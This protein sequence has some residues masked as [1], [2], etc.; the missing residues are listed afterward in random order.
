MLKQ[1]RRLRR[2]PRLVPRLQDGREPNPPLV[3]P[4]ALRH[5]ALQIR[6]RDRE[7]QHGELRHGKAILR[8]GRRL[9]PHLLW[10]VERVGLRPAEFHHRGLKIQLSRGIGVLCESTRGGPRGLRGVPCVEEVRRVGKLRQGPLSE[11]RH[12]AVPAM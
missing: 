1:C 10:H 11:P 9:G 12:I 6:P 4:P 2:S 5:V 8:L 7:H 3:G